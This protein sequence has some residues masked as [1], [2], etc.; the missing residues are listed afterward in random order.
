M[1]FLFLPGL[2]TLLALPII[3]WLH[4]RRSRLKR[5]IVPSLML[6]QHLPVPQTVKRRR[7][8]PLTLLLLLHLLVAALL[9]LAIGFPYGV[10]SI[11]TRRQHTAIIIDTSTSMGARDGAGGTR[12]DDARSQA[13]GWF[14]QMSGDDR[15][16]LI[17]A[18]QQARLLTS[19]TVGSRV[20]L[21]QELDTLVPGGEST[22]I[23]GALILAQTLLNQPD[24][25]GQPYDTTPIVVLSDLTQPA[26][27]IQI[28]HTLEWNRIGG[29]PG[30]RALVALAA[31]PRGNRSTSGYNV[32]ARVANYGD[33]GLTTQLNLYADDVLVDR[34]NV[35]LK[36]NGEVGL[37]WDVPA[38]T[39]VV[40][41]EIDGQDM[42]PIDDTASLNLQPARPLKTLLVSSN[43]GTLEHA[44]QAVPG[45]NLV[46]MGP[47][48]Y[49]TSPLVS[50]ADLVVFDGTL[51]AT[52]S[53]PDG[54]VLVVNPPVESQS[55]LLVSPAQPLAKPVTLKVEEQ[56]QT[57]L[58]GLNL[59]GVDFGLVGRLQQPDWAHPVLS[60]GDVPLIVQGQLEQ[61]KI[62]IWTF[63]LNQ[64]SITTRLAF[65]LLVARTVQDLSPLPLP[66]TLVPGSPLMI[67]PGPHTQ[68]VEVTAP[69]HTTRRMD[70]EKAT[71][72]LMLDDL[73]EPGLYTIQEKKGGDILYESYVAVNAGTPQESDLRPHP[74]PNVSGVLSIAAASAEHRLTSTENEKAQPLWSWFMLAALTIGM[75]EWI[76]IQFKA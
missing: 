2:L 38:G 36:P 64:S 10:T 50:R 66:S 51:T 65:P 35:M 61:R 6:W 18:G 5:V 20:L 1:T 41:T 15:M 72:L 14:N 62:A 46:T 42:L 29:N 68:T 13:R 45:V 30:N 27:P 4:L 70:V 9:G 19:G 55:L 56:G 25:K 59:S 12:L 11:A 40:R 22:D 39:R 24:E 54:G 32:F 8:L 34:H 60:A 49:Q 43:P 57:L 21:E 63:D 47:G 48:A 76:Y 7:W 58:D 67:E 23:A 3:V 37:R 16:T 28:G 71:R 75:I 31:R 44:L 53:W 73:V 26:E 52:V 69:D 17:E 33:S 74:A